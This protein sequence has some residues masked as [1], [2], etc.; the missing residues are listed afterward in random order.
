MVLFAGIQATHDERMLE[1]AV[2]RTLGGSRKQIL[3]ALVAEFV[4]LGLL[5]GFV[6]AILASA[7]AFAVAQYVLKM[8]VQWNMSVWTYGLFGGAVGIGL[9]G[10]WGSFGVVR[11]PPLQVFK[12]ITAAN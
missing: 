8:P 12:K 3:Q 7:V 11:Q 4:S 5:A 10:V 9:V 6:A 1:N 2:V